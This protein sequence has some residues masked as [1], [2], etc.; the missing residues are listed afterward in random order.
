MDHPVVVKVRHLPQVFVS[1][2]ARW[3]GGD[4]WSVVMVVP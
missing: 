1:N 4:R 3:A 2:L